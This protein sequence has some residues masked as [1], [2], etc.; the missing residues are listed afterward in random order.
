MLGHILSSNEWDRIA[1]VFAKSGIT[2]VDD[3]DYKFMIDML[4]ATLNRSTEQ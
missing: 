1:A 2:L 4:M 3:L